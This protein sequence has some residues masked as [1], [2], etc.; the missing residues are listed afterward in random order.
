MICVILIM[1][2]VNMLYFVVD[3]NLV[4]MLLVLGDQTCYPDWLF[5]FVRCECVVYA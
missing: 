5:S 4:N 1:I 2:V 3:H